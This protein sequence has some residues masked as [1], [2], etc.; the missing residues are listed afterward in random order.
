MRSEGDEGGIIKFNSDS[1]ERSD[2][3]VAAWN[4][5]MLL[6]SYKP[7][8]LQ[9][10]TQGTTKML[11]LPIFRYDPWETRKGGIDSLPVECGFTKHL[12]LKLNYSEINDN[13]TDIKSPANVLH[14]H[15]LRAEHIFPPRNSLICMVNCSPAFIIHVQC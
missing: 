4:G 5:S 13:L 1:K 8:A 2:D 7:L 10:P 6:Q 9:Q 3:G 11:T 12:R 14:I 15:L